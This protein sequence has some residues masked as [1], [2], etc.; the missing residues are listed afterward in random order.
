MLIAEYTTER[1][2]GNMRLVVEG[3]LLEGEPYAEL[4]LLCS[5]AALVLSWDTEKGAREFVAITSL[6]GEAVM[7]LAGA[8]AEV[9]E[10]D[11]QRVVRVKPMLTI[12]YS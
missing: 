3:A 7:M 9:Y 6:D 12:G 2:A 4:T 11:T 1:T 8:Q 10:A 5:G